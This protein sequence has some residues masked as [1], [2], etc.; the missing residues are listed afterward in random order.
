MKIKLFIFPLLFLIT[1]IS[2]AQKSSP[3]KSSAPLRIYLGDWR[4]TLA[5]NDSTDL[6]FTFTIDLL[7][8]GYTLTIHN[9]EENIMVEDLVVKKDSISWHM[10]VFDSWFKCKIDSLKRF[11][12]VFTNHSASKPYEMNF[13]AEYNKGRFI[14]GNYP[15]HKNEQLVGKWECTFSPGTPDSSKAVGIFND[16][17][18]K[19]RMTGT[20]LTETGDYRFLEGRHGLNNTFL[21]SCFDGSHAFFFKARLGKDGKLHGNAWY[22]KFGYEPWTGRRNPK[23]ELRDPAKLTFIKDSSN[24]N[25]T[26]NDLNGNPVSL[27]DYKGKVVVIQIMGSWCPNCMDET[28]WMTEVYN[29]YHS[30]GLEVI[31][32]AYER[33]ADTATANPNIRRVR[34]HFNASYTFL[35]TGKTGRDA[36]SESLAFLNGIMSFPTTIYI[37]KEGKVR[38]VY[39]GFNGPATGAAYEKD[40]AEAL[41]L[42]QQMLAEKK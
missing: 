38:M 11:H 22:G 34:D 17:E 9:A 15:Y 13:R 35:N 27:S 26:F 1:Q 7:V 8:T 36:A 20:F 21:L 16:E 23:F 33:S 30:Q 18:A 39:T 40:T 25:F 4:G 29:K 2:F 12:G 42:I 31:A 3:P 28:A 24:V 6:P 37:D 19:S 10:P 32:L 5:M 14:E 41:R